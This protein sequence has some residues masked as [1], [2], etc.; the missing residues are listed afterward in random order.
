VIN[1]DGSELV[2][3][4]NRETNDERATINSDG[5]KIA[6][7]SQ[8]FDPEIFVANLQ[9]FYEPAINHVVVFGQASYSISTCSNST[10]SDLSFNQELGRIT[11][12]ATGTYG[13]TGFCKIVIPS[14]MMSGTF[15]IFKDGTPLVENI[16]YTQIYN[17][18]H[19]TLNITY[20]HSTHTIEIFST[21]VIPELTSMIIVSTFII[22]TIVVAIYGRKNSKKQKS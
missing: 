14:A 16:D 9:I 5:S 18:T 12:S 8:D 10:V 2:R 22:T 11:F 7:E 20:E 17:G 13:T 19:Y 6:F 1:S 15:T 21:T 4:T 3:I